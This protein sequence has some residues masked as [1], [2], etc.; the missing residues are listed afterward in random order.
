MIAAILTA[1]SVPVMEDRYFSLVLDG[2]EEGERTLGPIGRSDIYFEP[3]EVPEYL[4]T[5][6]LAMQLGQNEVVLARHHYWA[7]PLDS[8]IHRVLSR[9]IERLRGDRAF[10]RQAAT[11]TCRLAIEFSRFHTSDNSQLYVTGMFTLSDKR[12]SKLQRFD[13]SR[14]LSADGFSSAVTDM[15]RALALLARQISRSLGDLQCGRAE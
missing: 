5:R 14:G 8:S 4:R 7:E 13:H 2:L 3:V 11:S 1:C 15:R 9:E 10:S 6:N 12:G